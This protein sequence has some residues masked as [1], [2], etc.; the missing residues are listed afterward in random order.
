[1]A[2]TPAARPAEE[3]PNL[4]IVFTDIE[5]APGFYVNHIEVAHNLHEIELLFGRLPAKIEPE[6]AR[7]INAVR[8]IEI[9]LLVKIIIPP[10]LLDDFIRVLQVQRE[11]FKA[12][13]AQIESKESE[14]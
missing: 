6:R 4:S 12:T 14:K 3:A 11:K 9:E 13:R 7:E 8:R 2:R 10:T 1:M 5:D